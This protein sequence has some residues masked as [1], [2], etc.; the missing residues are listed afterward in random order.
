MTTTDTIGFAILGTG[1]VADYHQQAIKAN[2]EQGARLVGVGHYDPD[3]FDAIAARFGAPCRS[4]EALLAD[5][6]VD[7]VCICTPSGQHAQQALAAIQAGKHVLVEKPMALSL[8]DADAMIEAAKE[9]NVRLGVVLQR[10]AEPLFQRVHAAIQAGDLGD[11]TLAV[12]T[13]PYVRPQ[14]YYEQA[15]WRGTWGLDGGGVL[16]NQGI[17]IV[18][19]LVWFMGDPVKIQAQADTL[20]RDVAVE[21][22]LAADLRFANGSLAT[23]TATTTAAPGFPHRLEIYGNGGGIQLEGES[24]RRW[25]LA[26]PDRAQVTPFEVSREEE[27]A[28]AGGDPRGI[29]ASG[30]IAIAEAFVAA[31]HSGED[32][33]IDGHEGRRSLATVLGVYEAAGIGG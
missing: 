7:A 3:R 26:K 6:A 12:V 31:I 8:A 10:R 33:A 14:S 9:A 4:Y 11:L 1:M 21:D 18:D 32:P 5:P 27:D 19:L 30:H 29:Q 2:A 28:G 20:H 25:T 13:M 17:H 15:E 16:M 22:T 23:I 24:V